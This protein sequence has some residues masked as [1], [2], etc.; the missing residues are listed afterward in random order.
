MAYHD[1]RHQRVRALIDILTEAQGA[2]ESAEYQTLRWAGE[3]PVLGFENSVVLGFVHVF[4]TPAALLST[5]EQRSMAVLQRFAPLLRSGG[6]KAWNVYTVLLADA[7]GNDEEK[8]QLS[9]IE[10]DMSR[11][12]K[13]A[14]AG[15]SNRKALYDALLPLLPLAGKTHLG[16][17]NFAA[18]LERRA[19]VPAS[20]IAALLL[21]ESTEKISDMLRDHAET[22]PT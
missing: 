8:I 19:D 18:E 2:F 15:L 9:K 11:T 1:K 10:E 14:R 4:D 16:V 21:G 22:R 13:I 7:E 12:R 3:S 6:A 20:S 5:W 17:V